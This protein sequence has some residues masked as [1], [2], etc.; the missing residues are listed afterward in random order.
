M[1]F[2]DFFSQQA[3]QS[4]PSYEQRSTQY[5]DWYNQY[6]QNILARTQQWANE[7]YVT[8]GGP[9]IA[10]FSQD[11]Q[12]AMS[13][14]RNMGPSPYV[15]QAAE[16]YGSAMDP[17]NSGLAAAS[18][19]L[20]QAAQTFPSMASAYMS[21]YVDQVVNRIK[22]VG[23]RGFNENAMPA[24]DNTV[25]RAGQL[26]GSSD[27]AD[28]GRRLAR[29][30]N[31]S[32]MGAAAQA[33]E[34]GYGQAG[35][36]FGADAG[37]ALQ[38]GS[39]AGQLSAQDR[40]SAIS[41]GAGLTDLAKTSQGMDLSRFGALFNTGAAQQGWTQSNLDLA[42]KDFLQQRDWPMTQTQAMTGVL[43]NIRMPEGYQTYK[44]GPPEGAGFGASGLQQLASFLALVAA[45][46]K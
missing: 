18:P 26:Y 27:Q 38:T 45:A 32:I 1:A 19:Y 8:Y 16:A 5:P 21:P 35:Q 22:D 7:P 28:M 15:P 12:T 24:L 23:W 31:E 14:V 41:A 44:Y 9:R 25:A 13:G 33:L 43:P 37:R 42:Y 40:N 39:T 30:T 36:L 46:G 2:A 4:V 10:N 6:T 17:A 29:D 3:P 34:Q 20:A 11:Q